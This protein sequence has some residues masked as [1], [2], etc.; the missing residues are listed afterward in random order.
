MPRGF[1][2]SRS[3][4]EI[5]RVLTGYNTDVSFEGR[6][7]HV[8]SEDRGLE[9]PI[10]DT[11]V[12]T[13]GQIVHQHKASY[14]DLI[15]GG[16]VD[17]A[18][19]AR[20]LD[21]QHREFVRRARHGEFALDETRTLSEVFPGDGPLIDPLCRF[22]ESDEEVRLLELEWRPAGGEH[23]NTGRLVVK[24]AETHAPVAE[25][26]VTA[27]L[28]AR[29]LDPVLLLEGETDDEGELAV[30]I[31]PPPAVASA[32]IFSIDFASGIGRLR[33]EMSGTEE[34]VS[35]PVEEVS[36]V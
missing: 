2:L 28:V 26:P 7:Y 13:G 33:V 25:A 4:T 27:R 18:D 24:D 16:V 35:P 29:G 1:D 30:A 31:A 20:R 6:V 9:S 36:A 17:D 19:L 22:I 12:Y 15:V 5:V 10:L 3:A 32:I 8:Q 34:T 21:A 23:R 11:L 14:E